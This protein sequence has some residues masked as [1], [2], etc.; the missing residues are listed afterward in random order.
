[1]NGREVLAVLREK[2][3]LQDIPVVVVSPRPRKDWT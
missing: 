3:A 2:P 1:M